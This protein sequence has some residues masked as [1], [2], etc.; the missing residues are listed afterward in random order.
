MT[1]FDLGLRTGRARRW[2]AWFF[3][4]FMLVALNGCGGAPGNA[5][6]PGPPSHKKSKDVKKATD[7]NPDPSETPESPDGYR[8]GP[9][10]SKSSEPGLLSR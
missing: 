8:L 7:A 2:L 10:Q 9:P 4:G 5:P 6:P 3:A 1:A